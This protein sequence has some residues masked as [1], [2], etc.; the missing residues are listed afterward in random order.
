[1]HETFISENNT[2]L[3][4]YIASYS[5]YNFDQQNPLGAHGLTCSKP[6]FKLNKYTNE[7]HRGRS[8]TIT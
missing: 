3:D 8:L 6:L 7:N 2:L 5:K 4:L 1:M